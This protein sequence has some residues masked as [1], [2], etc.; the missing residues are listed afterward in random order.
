MASNSPWGHRLFHPFSPPSLPPSPHSAV[1]A[2]APSS[3]S[4]SAL[5]CPAPP[6]WLQQLTQRK[7]A[8]VARR[9]DGPLRQLVLLSN[10]FDGLL[11]ISAHQADEDE[12]IQRQEEER[13]WFADV[14]EQMVDGDGSADGAFDDEG[15]VN[16]R[17]RDRPGSDDVADAA[18]YSEPYAEST[19]TLLMPCARKDDA[20]NVHFEPAPETADCGHATPA[21]TPDAS[22]ELSLTCVEQRGRPIQSDEDQP[23]IHPPPLTPD[24]SPPGLG[25][26]SAFLRGTLFDPA[27]SGLAL[28]SK[29]LDDDS[30][31][32]TKDD[33]TWMIDH[34][35]SQ[36]LSVVRWTRGPRF[37]PDGQLSVKLA[38]SSHRSRSPPSR[39]PPPW[40]TR[41]SELDAVDFGP[42]F[43]VGGRRI[44]D[45][46][47]EF[48]GQ[49]RRRM[50]WSRVVESLTLA[51]D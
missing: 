46:L 51:G 33:D 24:S 20:G 34:S 8:S 26:A 31:L 47:D 21:L 48:V 35:P 32:S 42:P 39:T 15:Y 25:P 44:R 11:S 50:A 5:A 17:Y 2:S 45:D 23:P 49:Q 43:V 19:K 36:S 4:T 3:P 37:W 9:G 13:R 12:L 10:A 38:S 18:V 41:P 27:L 22:Y 1:L 14:F 30:S 40:F 29:D 28:E 16:L 7:I 6:A